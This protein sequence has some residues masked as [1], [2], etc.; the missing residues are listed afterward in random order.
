MMRSLWDCTRINSTIASFTF[1]S[2]SLPTFSKQSTRS[3][4]TTLLKRAWIWPRRRE[5]EKRQKKR[6]PASG[7]LCSRVFTCL[8]AGLILFL[9]FLTQH[10]LFT[11]TPLSYGCSHY[12]SLHTH[13][14]SYF[15][16]VKDPSGCHLYFINIDISSEG[17][18]VGRGVIILRHQ[19]FFCLEW[20]WLLTALLFLKSQ[21][22]S[23]LFAKHLFAIRQW[24]LLVQNMFQH[25]YL[26]GLFNSRLYN[27]KFLHSRAY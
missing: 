4:K 6:E 27:L 10:R 1:V 16:P 18:V 7:Q 21:N 14:A 11:R 12:L 5:L 2:I 20:T 9:S 25:T 22:E 26:M 8:W 19:Q 24:S 13:T 15:P 17:C 23:I 3:G